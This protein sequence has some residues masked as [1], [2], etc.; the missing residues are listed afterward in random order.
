MRSK[1]VGI[2]FFSLSPENEEMFWSF[3]FSLSSPGNMEGKT[4]LGFIC[5]FPSTHGRKEGKSLDK[6]VVMA[7]AFFFFVFLF[8]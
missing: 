1:D 7:S 3:F 6:G 8:S 4:L 2:A 5:L